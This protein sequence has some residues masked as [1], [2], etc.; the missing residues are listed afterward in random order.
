ME[1]REGSAENMEEALKINATLPHFGMRDMS[2]YWLDPQIPDWN[3]PMATGN[4]GPVAC[5][6]EIMKVG[7]I[8][9]VISL[10]G[11]FR[12]HWNC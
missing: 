4:N 6:K 1:T 3:A 8:Q 12:R 2:L 11:F 10:S 5:K 9:P 7:K